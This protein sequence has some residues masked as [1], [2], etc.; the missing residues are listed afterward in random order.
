MPDASPCAGRAV[1]VTRPRHRARAWIEALEALGASVAPREVFSVES[2]AG[3]PAAQRAIDDLAKFDWILLSSRNGLRFFQRALE[4]RG[5]DPTSVGARFSTVGPQT[6]AAL[7]AIGV[8][9][10]VVGEP[11]N[12]VGLAAA[13]AKHVETGQRLLIVR[14]DRSR[15]ELVKALEARGARIEDVPFY[16]NMPAPGLHDVARELA[17]RRFDAALFS[18]PSAVEYLYAA[19]GDRAANDFDAVALVAIGPT[20]AQALREHGCKVA[21][22]A[23]Q[24]TPEGIA[25]AVATALRR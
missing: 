15:P 17:D 24:P 23:Q 5:I 18:A 11:A 9:A 14:P 8:E 2:M 13:M 19:C 6:A 3:E 21:A 22:K 7:E 12:A 1:L 25:E 10:A 4:A 20:T 16:R